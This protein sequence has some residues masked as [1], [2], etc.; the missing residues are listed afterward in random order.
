MTGLRSTYND[1]QSLNATFLY[2]F[3]TNAYLALAPMNSTRYANAATLAPDGQ[4]L[5]SG[6]YRQA[7]GID[8]QPLPSA[9]LYTP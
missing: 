8:A 4:V 6:G 2:A 5:I 1:T 7:V 9:E 3:A